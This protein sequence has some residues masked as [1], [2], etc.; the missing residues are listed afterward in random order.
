GAFDRSDGGGIL[1]HAAGQPTASAKHAGEA[2][3]GRHDAAEAGANRA[4]RL[5]NPALDV[6]LP[7]CSKRLI[8]TRLDVILIVV[9]CAAVAEDIGERRIRLE[10]GAGEA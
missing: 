9:R 4:E 8:D 2:A 5:V 6:A 10:A 7:R 1:R 3:G